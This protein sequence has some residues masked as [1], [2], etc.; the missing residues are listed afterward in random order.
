MLF[1]KRSNAPDEELYR[2]KSD[3]PP[4][5]DD[6]HGAATK[7]G[8]MPLVDL[9]MREAE[10][11]L[12]IH[13]RSTSAPRLDSRRESAARESEI[14]G[15]ADEADALFE[16]TRIAEPPPDSIKACLSGGEVREASAP[17]DPRVPTTD[18]GGAVPNDTRHLPAPDEDAIPKLS[19]ED[20]GHPVERRTELIV[21]GTEPGSLLDLATLESV[22][23]E[24]PPTALPE[25]TGGSMTFAP[26]ENSRSDLVIRAAIALGAFLI[27]AGVLLWMFFG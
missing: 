18:G 4:A 9:L 19:S 12:G 24:D 16:P 10:N 20:D 25:W 27:T 7:V 2:V 1:S 26:H 23:P 11:S 8:S 13:S 5:G 17:S 22:R 6:P 21:A 15:L 3:P 14:P